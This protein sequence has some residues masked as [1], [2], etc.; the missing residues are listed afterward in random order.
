[1]SETYE[2]A[3]V[4]SRGFPIDLAIRYST[5]NDTPAVIARVPFTVTTQIPERA[6]WRIEFQ[7]QVYSGE[8]F[9]AEALMDTRSA[10]GERVAPGL[11][12]YKATETFFYSTGARPSLSVDGTVE[13]RR[14][15]IWPFGFSWMSSY[16]TL[17]VDRTDT[18]TIIQGDG[19]YLTF[20]RG[21]SGRYVPPPEEF[22][23][24][25]RLFDGTW[26][27]T[28]KHGITQKF[29]P[30]G[31]LTRIADRNGNVQELTY[32]ANGES[33]PEGAWG[34]VDR[35]ISITDSSGGTYHFSYGAQ[36]YVSRVTDPAG[37]QYMLDHDEQGDLISIT[38]PLGR[39]THYGY[40]ENHLLGDFTYPEGNTTKLT[41][42]ERRRLLTH[43]D[44]L[45]G[46]RTAE[47][48]NSRNVF[49]DES[50]V[51][52][53]YQFNRQGAITQVDNPVWGADYQWDSRR[54]YG[55][56]DQPY[57]RVDYDE[58][59]NAVQTNS[60]ITV[61]TTFEPVYNQ[62]TSV[63]DGARNTTQLAYD[64]LGNLVSITDALNNTSRL[65][66]NTFGQVIHMTDPLNN[67]IGM[68]YD[69]FGNQVETTDA[70]GFRTQSDY[71]DRGNLTR[72]EDAENHVIRFSY[73]AM[74]RMAAATDALGQSRSFDYDRNDNL[75]RFE[76]ARNNATSFEFD[77]LDRLSSE[78]DPLGQ[79]TRYAYD[80][81]GNL[82]S[83]MRADS[84]SSNFSYDAANRLI[85][86]QHPDGRI[87]GYT[88]NNIHDLTSIEDGN[89]RVVYDYSSQ[90]AGTA[91]E[92]TTEL[93]GPGIQSAVT[94]D[95]VVV[96]NISVSTS[97][98]T[99][100]NNHE[101]NAADPPIVDV[102]PASSYD[103]S[104]LAEA[105]ESANSESLD[106]NSP[107]PD[108]A[109]LTSYQ[110]SITATSTDVCGAINSNTTWTPAGS[111]YIPTC[112]VTVNAGVTLTIQPGVVVKFKDFWTD[113]FI[114]GTLIAAGTEGNPIYFTSIKDDTIGG[115][116]NGDGSATSPAP[117]DWSSLVFASTS[118]GSVLEN[119]V[120]RYGGGQGRQ[121]VW[122]G[123]SDITIAH[124]TIAY[125]A[126][127]GMWL[128]NALPPVLTNN[129]FVDNGGTAIWA[130]LTSNDDSITLS[131]NKASGNE[132]NGM[133][134]QG[135]IAGDPTWDGDTLFP[136][137]VNSD[138][139]VNQG[140]SLTLTPGTTMKF[141]DFWTDFMVRGT[142]NAA[143]SEEEPIYFTSI[144]DDTVGGDTNDDGDLTKP[145]PDNWSS[146][147]FAST[148]TGSVLDHS[149]V[150]YGGGQGR[151]NVWVASTDITIANSTIAYSAEAGL[152]LDNALPPQL[153]NNL[154]LDNKGTAVWAQ[155]TNNDDSIILDGN[156]GSGNEYNGMLFQGTIA[157]DVT[158]DGD[159]L[160]PFVANN[161]VT[162]QQG[163]SLTLTPG[164]TVK[165]REF[166]TDLVVRGTLVAQGTSAQPIHFTSLQDDG[167][168]GD[169]N[170][171]G[172]NSVPAAGDWSALAF[173][174]SSTG[175]AL[176]Q[177]TIR[178]GGGQ[179]QYNVW[180]NTDDL[181]IQNSVIE[182]SQDY[183]IY[184]DNT[185]PTIFRN[186]IRD[187]RIG[188]FTL[189]NAQPALRENRLTR[190]SEYGLFNANRNNIIDAEDN[191]WGSVK[192]PY[193]PVDDTSS[194][195]WYNPE[196]D[197]DQVSNNVDYEHWLAYT[198][199]LYGTT[200]ATANN[201]VQTIRYDYDDLNRL[202]GLSA[203]GP[204]NSNV[205]YSYDAVSRL[206]STD[207]ASGNTG[208]STNFT[209]DANNRLTR[210][211]NQSPTAS[212]TFNDFRYSYDKIGNVLSAQDSSGTT[213]YGYNAIYQLASVSGPG[214]SESYGYDAAGNRTSKNSVTYTYNAANQLNSSSDGW[215]FNYDA[216]GNLR[217]KSQAGQTT[218]Y[219]WDSSDR[220]AKIDFP[221]GSYSEYSYDAL[222]RRISKRDRAGKITYFVYDGL[223]LVQEVAA[224]GAVLVNYVYDGLD[225]PIA[226][227]LN[228]TTYFYFYDQLG[229]VVGLSNGAGQVITTYRYDPWGNIIASAGSNP[230]LP[231]PFRYVGRE[232]DEES[233]LYYMRAR[234]YDPQTAQFISRDPLPA[235]FVDNVYAYAGNNPVNTSDP[236]G[237]NESDRRFWQQMGGV[238]LGAVGATVV[239]VLTA[240]ATGPTLIISFGATVV[241]TIVGGAGAAIHERVTVANPC[242]RDYLSAFGAG[243]SGGFTGASLATTGLDL[244]G[245]EIAGGARAVAGMFGRGSARKLAEHRIEQEMAVRSAE[246]MA[247]YFTNIGNAERAWEYWEKADKA[248]RVLDVLY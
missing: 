45:G 37:R 78:T 31:R 86:E 101:A 112:D 204:V 16:D 183:G 140:A 229:S 108:T 245:A 150:R 87:A 133:L 169:T 232:W 15:D 28:S 215:T 47:Y 27:R 248:R 134:F 203:S 141:K 188:I 195:G 244:W 118:T 161:D 33:I 9:M 220:L 105:P 154:F 200:I 81:V 128:D 205:R 59:G 238:V 167:P 22:S 25:T 76:D 92:V 91:D 199:L 160:F 114:R 158:W 174:A 1:M 179:G 79:T 123:S 113:L 153:T 144:K 230:N 61:M 102:I 19:Q 227:T 63:T 94:Y 224:D 129:T 18:V 74:D 193:D 176:D 127:A 164:S 137:V 138:V 247:R 57:Q 207:P 125:S 107:E 30:S 34:L 181:V 208:V 212:A 192:G 156:I 184:I 186:A 7:G 53:A 98:Q 67:T 239:V 89:A 182:T 24:L 139:T 242:E 166:F 194:G 3:S 122:V 48:F 84:T 60:H 236:F 104:E 163:A 46:V 23:T 29:N 221:D 73:D 109:G 50:G 10:L 136:F 191:W 173:H 120:V 52:T 40:D 96:G 90:I 162:I 171:D 2:F 231:N 64:S 65:E 147:V 237:T 111:P 197:G 233:G 55:G 26:S 72:L 12:P 146:L 11:Y 235:F 240:P 131:G 4:A 116:S 159:V 124:T 209:Y 6:E 39:I 216:N 58:K 80:A 223:S 135:T 185:S 241:G 77:D 190:N 217:T 145:G 21:E 85:Q 177:V 62:P 234:Y 196:G 157:G 41:Y 152:W 8:G 180:I 202:R 93:L 198:G 119:S 75:T 246:H 43:E 20:R 170:G 82:T 42:D 213:T 225:H 56:S 14:G 210:M 222:D 155:L 187:N 168:G 117:D 214:L 228:G 51:P 54:Q 5:N 106:V 49:T 201:P 148:S 38:D 149:V 69:L 103:I 142:L 143:A 68:S 121:N 151:Q 83:V 70:L 243:L 35:L 100:T 97:S 172:P 219:S 110:E 132:F 226:M 32:E 189:R 17:L 211:V 206:I 36:G 178:Y 13:V 44:A 71:D 88:Y 218:T 95:Y 126:E 165:F 175:S 130:H 115:D 66:Y 99:A